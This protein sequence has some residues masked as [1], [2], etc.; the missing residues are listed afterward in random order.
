MG[1]NTGAPSPLELPPRTQRVHTFV[2]A[3]ATGGEAVQS[4]LR[5]TGAMGARTSVDRETSFLLFIPCGLQA[6]VAQVAV[7]DVTVPTTD[8]V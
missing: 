1:C 2:H 8:Q 3:G 5:T 4:E 7:R 6:P